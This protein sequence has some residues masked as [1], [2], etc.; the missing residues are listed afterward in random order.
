MV[1]T[2]TDVNI[3][4]EGYLAQ[5][6]E[7]NRQTVGRTRPIALPCPL[8]R[9]LIV[10]VKLNSSGIGSMVHRPTLVLAICCCYTLCG[11]FVCLRFYHNLKNRK[12]YWYCNRIC[13]RTVGP[14]RM[15]AA[16][17]QCVAATA[18]LLLWYG[19]TGGQMLCA[20][21][22]G[23]GQHNNPVSATQDVQRRGTL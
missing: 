7:W 2:H 8:R 16:S 1:M 12:C 15:L 22:Y 20:C 23:R 9:P 5:N 19:L 6:I 18:L 11:R 21:R 13:P 10:Q 4:I 14:K 17:P 3:K